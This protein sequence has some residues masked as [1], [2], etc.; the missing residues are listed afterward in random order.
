MV[1]KSRSTLPQ[2]G[3]SKQACLIYFKRQPKRLF[4][5]IRQVLTFLIKYDIIKYPKRKGTTMQWEYLLGSLLTLFIMAYGM[6]KIL[7]VQKKFV[8]V[9]K[10]GGRKLTRGIVNLVREVIALPFRM[11]RWGW[12]RLSR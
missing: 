8:S 9:S 6:A 2:M 11:I 7:G 10:K 4:F 12:R 1:T 5:C 3:K